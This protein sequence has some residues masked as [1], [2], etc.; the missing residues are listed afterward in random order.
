MKLYYLNLFIAL[1]LVISLSGCGDMDIFSF[2]DKTVVLD[3]AGGL[4]NALALANTN[5]ITE[6]KISGKMD[7]RDFRTIRDRMPR[8]KQLDLS[9]VTIEA[10]KGLDGTGETGIYD[11]PANTIPIYAFY[12]PN[13]A[14]SLVNLSKILFPQSMKAIGF[15]AFAG[16][17]G[18]TSLSFP[19]SLKRI[20]D[21]SFARCST[22]T[23]KLT[24]PSQV[25][26]IGYSAFTY[27][28]AITSVQLSDSLLFIGESAFNGCTAL[29]GTLALPSKIT[30]INDRAFESC[31]SLSAINIPASLA[32][33]GVSVFQDCVCPINVAT[34]NPNFSSIG[35]VLFDAGQITLKYFPATKTGNYDIPSTVMIIDNGAFSNCKGLTSISIPATVMAIGDYT[36]YNCSGLSGTINIPNSVF[37]IGVFAFQGCSGI[38]AFNV[39]SDNGSLAS[40]DGVIFDISLTTLMQFPPAKV[41][42]YNIPGSTNTIVQGAF[43]DCT[44]LTSVSIPAT[45][46]SIGD[47]AFMNCSGLT[48]IRSYATTPIS[49]IKGVKVTSW[50]VFDN[51][52]KSSCTLFVPSGSKNAYQNANQ[53][54]DFRNITEM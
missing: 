39:A 23:D 33:L 38:S 48:S 17:T 9:N 5:A 18:L 53:W 31:S 22:L 45:V 29:A 20:G 10:Y 21:R 11:Y 47:R 1:S 37:A 46:T 19:A 50:S 41:G 26:T 40:V 44:A 13:T 6:L 25:D 15:S 42:S 35:G 16:C 8:L 7:S 14:V 36:F 3:K 4:A 2:D 27:C 51:V 54:K 52:N 12:N 49:F 28:T 30:T 32:N 34:D 43:L 24:I